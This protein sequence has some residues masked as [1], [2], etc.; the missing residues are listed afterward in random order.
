MTA[1]HSFDYELNLL[2]LEL[3]EMGTM[4][5]EAVDKSVA[6]LYKED[7][8][9]QQ[10]VFQREEKIDQ[11]EK[12]IESR[13]LGLIIRQQ[14]VASDLRQISAALKV[15][16]DIERIGDNAADITEISNYIDKEVPKSTVPQIE[17]MCEYA[18]EMVHKSIQ[19]FVSKDTDLAQ[20]IIDMDDLVDDLFD[21]VKVVLTKAIHNRSEIDNS[22]IDFLMIAKYLER[23]ADHA[24]NICEWAQ[25]SQTGNH[26][27]EKIM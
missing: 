5:K 21:E 13:C 17:K 10:E 23:I 16:T 25:F 8:L 9:L 18:V 11:M 26:K 3:T 12:Q 24:V 22:I 14:P 7:K 20:R 15:I 27:R 19:A 2:H 1:R 6:C 4:A